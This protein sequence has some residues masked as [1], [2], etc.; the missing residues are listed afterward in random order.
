LAINL[1]NTFSLF[2]YYANQPL[3]DQSNVYSFGIVLLE[4]ISGRKP[5]SVE[6][7]GSEWNIVHWVW[8][9][10]LFQSFCTM[11]DIRNQ[12]NTM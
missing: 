11:Q 6:D 3:T 12:F 5:F 4:F 7:Y 10:Y 2:R 1:I 8:S 9:C